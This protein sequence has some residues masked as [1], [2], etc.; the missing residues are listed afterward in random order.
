MRRRILDLGAIDSSLTLR[1][2]LVSRYTKLKFQ[3]AP[4]S[5]VDRPAPLVDTHRGSVE[6]LTHRQWLA[7]QLHSLRQL[8]GVGDKD[9]DARLVALIQ[10]IQKECTRL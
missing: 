2:R 5:I 1:A 7:Y 9:A 10:K 3:R 4:V 6:F 8:V